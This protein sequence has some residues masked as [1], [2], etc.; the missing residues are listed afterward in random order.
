MWHA[1]PPEA[2]SCRVHTISYR[3]DKQETQNQH[4]AK[5][6]TSHFFLGPGFFLSFLSPLSSHNFFGQPPAIQPS[7]HS[8]HGTMPWLRSVG[9]SAEGK[10]RRAL[11]LHGR[12]APAPRS[13]V[14]QFDANCRARLGEMD[15]GATRRRGWRKLGDVMGALG[16][17]VSMIF[18][19]VRASWFR[20]LTFLL[21]L[22]KTS[23]I[24]WSCFFSQKS[25]C[26]SLVFCPR[27]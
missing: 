16:R 4:S 10:R 21:V 12:P 20:D 11:A 9:D 19:H 24:M 27:E 8:R 17:C 13:D 15:R 2:G 1:P 3:S 25:S 22:K 6:L 18:S 7:L 26:V 5:L 14:P 23:C